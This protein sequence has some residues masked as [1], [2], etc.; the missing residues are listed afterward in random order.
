MTAREAQAEANRRWGR[1]IVH[2]AVQFVDGV[3]REMKYVGPGTRTTTGGGIAEY[4]RGETWEAAFADAD[5]WADPEQWQR[6]I[7]IRL[8]REKGDDL[9]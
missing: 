7:W 6:G 1:G 2:E 8:P 4:G 3:R 5:R 9:P